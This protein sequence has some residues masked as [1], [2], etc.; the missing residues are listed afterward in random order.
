MTPLISLIIVLTISIAIIFGNYKL[1]KKWSKILK[2]TLGKIGKISIVSISSLIILIL[3]ITAGILINDI[4]ENRLKKY[5]E[6]QGIKLG[7]ARDEV[8]FR[9]GNPSEI[10]KRPNNK[11]LDE[12]PNLRVYYQDDKVRG[13]SKFCDAYSY[14]SIN[15]LV[16]QDNLDKLLKTLG[17]S[18]D[19]D[20][21]NDKTSRLYCYPKYNVCYE[22]KLANI[23][24][25]Y[26]GDMQDGSVLHYIKPE[27][28]KDIEVLNTPPKKLVPPEDLPD[29][30]KPRTIKKENKSFNS[31][32]YLKEN[33]DHCAP[34]LS[35]EE[36]IKRLGLKGNIRQTGANSFNAGSNYVQ[37][38]YYGDLINCY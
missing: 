26:V 28:Q 29:N 14:N 19:V 23:V 33:S 13:I 12:Y 34:N 10:Q 20:V 22:V 36:R 27:E 6:F 31:D 1:I 38:S 9:L 18:K 17:E 35:K 7:W 8:L 32:E 24:S 2:S 30:L 37:F 4:W 3:L 16:C 21:S 25:M 15:G 11:Q 5:D